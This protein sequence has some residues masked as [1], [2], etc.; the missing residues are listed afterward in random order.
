M[1]FLH[2]ISTIFWLLLLVIA[3][4]TTPKDSSSKDENK[5]EEGAI[6]ASNKEETTTVNSDISGEQFPAETGYKGRYND[7]VIYIE[8]QESEIKGFVRN[9][10]DNSENQLVGTMASPFDFNATEI[11]EDQDGEEVTVAKLHGKMEDDGQ[12]IELD[13]NDSNSAKTFKVSL[14]R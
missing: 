10:K 7:Y 11:I 5:T 14:K 2:T 12:T 4:N 1:K 9:K 8:V 13:Y 6:A 3:C